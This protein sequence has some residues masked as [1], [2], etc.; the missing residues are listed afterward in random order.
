[1]NEILRN[2]LVQEIIQNLELQIAQLK[3]ERIFNFQPEPR[4]TQR[5]YYGVRNGLREVNSCRKRRICDKF[6][7]SITAWNNSENNYL[8]K[9]KLKCAKMVL[10][11]EDFYT[12]L[13]FEIDITPPLEVVGAAERMT[14]VEFL[15]LKDRFNISNII[16]NLIRQHK[17]DW[18]SLYM[19]GLIKKSINL[20]FPIHQLANM[21]FYVEPSYWINFQLEHLAKRNP[22]IFLNKNILIKIELDGFILA[23]ETNLLNFSFAVIN[24]G[25]IAASAMGTYPIGFFQ[26]EKENYDELEKIVPEIWSKIEIITEFRYNGHVYRIIYLDCNDHKMQAIVSIFLMQ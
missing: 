4:E 22:I 25:K 21:G 11:P 2:P 5:P 6:K 1:M 15:Y 9:Y 14:N 7:A 18:P 20:L 10:V 12:E 8:R 16:W 3:A 19:L 24:E 13:E 23:R 26:I 17:P